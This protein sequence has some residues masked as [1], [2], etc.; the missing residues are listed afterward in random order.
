MVRLGDVF[1]ITSGGTPLK[2]KNEYYNNGTIPWV[3]T[4]NLK[5][6]FITNGTDMITQ[7]GLMNSSAKMFPKGTVLI[8]M[9]GA[10]IGACSILGIE[11]STNQA[12]AAFLPNET[13]NNSYLYYFL[14]SHKEKL[15][16]MG[17]GGAQPNI[18]GTILK[19]VEISLPPLDIQ[20]NIA[21]TLDK[22]Q[23][24]IEGHKRQFEELDNLIKSTFY[25]MFGD[26]I[27][28]NKEWDIKTFGDISNVRQGLQIAIQNRKKEPGLNRHKY[29]TVQYLN[30][31]KGE[32]YIENPKET[33]VCRK[34]D[35]LMT[36]TGN[37]G[38][39]ITNAEGVFHNN[40]FLIDYDRNILEKEFV[41]SFLRYPSI[42][43][44]LIRRA[45]TSTIPDLNHSE[46]YKIKIYLPPKGLQNKFA[47]IV[48]NIEEQ[49]S[50]VK[51]SITQSQ[52]LFNSLVS[53]Y[54]DE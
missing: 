21:D 4:G 33:V 54:F 6:K 42:Q 15:I 37:T 32:E 36:R 29:I 17:V 49:K 20:K 46:F 16:R 12:C 10:T 53:K 38:M 14:I 7:A 43:A 11:A 51:Q 44:D 26:P 52:N 3:K 5:H 45:T 41:L 2:T 8:A 13:V 25:N 39:V 24:I 22:T 1:K 27:M 40:F 50:L 31:N 19:S 34:S 28:N 48:T 9:Y 30:G 35:I 47:E 23:E 18:S